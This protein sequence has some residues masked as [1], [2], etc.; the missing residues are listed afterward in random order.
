[1]AE[2]EAVVE[3]ASPKPEKNKKTVTIVIVSLLVLLLVAGG[4]V[5]FLMLRKPEEPLRLG[6]GGRG[7][8]AT[9]DNIDK[10]MAD[11]D[12]PVEDGQYRTRMNIVWT[13]PAW[14]K[15]SDA[16]VENAP[17]NTRTVYF[18][19]FL[20]ETRE[21]IYSSPYITVGAALTGF[22]LDSEVP[23]GTHEGTVTY[24]LVDDNFEEL[25]TVSVGVKLKI[26]K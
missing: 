26:E 23:A 4:I 16:I 9:P 20:D 15:G 5:I 14:N 19:V 3:N 2:I 13:F 7:I 21:L 10:I 22:A 18:D 6:P 24:H 17:E 12:E 1:M 8:V 25:T 11:R